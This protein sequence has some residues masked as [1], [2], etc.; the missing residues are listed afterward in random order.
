MLIYNTTFYI[1][2]G[3]VS[4]GVDYL[5]KHYIPAAT[6]GGWAT[7]PWMSRVL[8]ASAPGDGE[9]ISV[10]F[11]I[12]DADTLDRWIA[13]CGQLL[14]RSLAERFGEKMVGFSTVLEEIDWRE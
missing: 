10:Q 9:S 5:K 13:Q 7:E 8:A 2:K 14:Q 11:R 4:E 3:V 12:A 6:A 1:E